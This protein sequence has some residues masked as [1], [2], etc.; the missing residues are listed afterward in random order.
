MML[1]LEILTGVITKIQV[2]VKRPAS[3][4]ELA[5]L[6]VDNNDSRKMKNTEKQ[7]YKLTEFGVKVATES[8]FT[9]TQ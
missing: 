6:I 8:D 5:Q 1:H 7:Q 4:K 3:P 2:E 9:T